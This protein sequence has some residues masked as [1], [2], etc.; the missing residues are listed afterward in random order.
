MNRTSVR[1]VGV[2]G[3][4]VTLLSL[5]AAPAFA[6]QPG[7]VQGR[8]IDAGTERPIRGAAVFLLGRDRPLVTD[9]DGRY[10]IGNV[11]AGAQTIR[12]LAL[13]YL[14]R[15]QQVTV[16]AGGSATADFGLERT[17]IP[18]D[19][20]VVTGTG[21]AVA[22][23]KLGTTLTVINAAEI[24]QAAATSVDPLLQGRTGGAAIMATSAQPGTGNM[25]S[26]RGVSSVAGSQMP[27]I[28]VDGVRV[29]NSDDTASGTGG[30]ESSALADLLVTD[31]ERIEITKGGAASTLYGS[32]AAAG[33]IQIFTKK[34]TPGPTRITARI[35]QGIDI[36][37]LKF[38]FDAGVIFPDVVADGE[39]ARFLENNFFRSG[40][41]Q[42]YYVGA[43]GGSEALT[44]SV[45]G[46]IQQA[47]GVQPK[48]ES[49]LFN[50]RGALQ[51]QLGNKSRVTFTANYTRSR[52]DRLF[53]GA[54]IA[55]PL[56]T[57]E[58]GD[59]LFFSNTDPCDAA[60]F[61][62]PGPE[63]TC[64]LHNALNIFLLPDIDETVNRF[65]FSTGLLY[66]GSDLF[67]LRGSVGLDYRA[68]HQREFEPIGFI[69]G[70]P[71]GELNR[72]NREFTS[73]S[74]DVAGTF[75][76]P[77]ATDSW[78]TSDFTV[79]VQGFRD[80]ISVVNANGNAFGLPGAPD[81]DEAA[82]VTAFE[83]NTEIFNGG[84]ILQEE[85]GLGDRV[86]LTG[87]LRI[88][89]NSTF[90]NDVNTEVYPKLSA[91]YLISDEDFFGNVFGNTVNS[92]KLRLAYGQTGKFPD[93]FLRDRSFSSIQ[94]R[95]ESAPTFANPGNPDLAPEVTAT[96]EG[97]FDV[98]L[99]S[100]RVGLHFTYYNA[101]T[102]DALF[103]V[104]EQ[105]STGQGTQLR[106]VGEVVNK[107]IEIEANFQIL[108]TR[109]VSLNFAGT[110]STVDNEVTKMG[111]ASPFSIAG[112][113]GNQ[114]IE[115]GHPIGAW[116]VNTPIDTNGDGLFDSFESQ[117][118][119]ESPIPTKLGTLAM[120]LTL[121]NNLSFSA[122]GDWATGFQAMDWGS[123]WATFNG[124][125][126]RELV[127]PGFVWPERFDLAGNPACS[128]PPCKFSQSQAR[129]ALLVDGDWFK[130]REIALR[131]RVP[132]TFARNFG[133]DRMTVYG[134]VRNLAIFSRN[135]MIDGELNGVR[136]AENLNLGGISSVTLSPPRQ[137]RFGFEVT[138]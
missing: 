52:F 56:T 27:F 73:V 107:G 58:V 71:E 114:R 24:E 25:I 14:A 16:A 126:R 103:R 81:F 86:F 4:L 100:N 5:V 8:V 96:L 47:D 136:S 80:D 130:L 119:G 65:R 68:N 9:D 79:G 135:P 66:R 128:D 77:R 17:A 111:S 138:F 43:D 120:N 49:E 6:Q 137:Y 133:I 101:K 11:P 78:W 31:I 74:V 41:A 131:Y 61:S 93:A 87:G 113:S 95:G 63:R 76:Y 110:Y 117:F 51:A 109:N 83:T 132:D 19:E 59:A 7:T 23:K 115:E 84:V 29:D 32:D 123:R 10:Q 62:T 124:I 3:C 38:M 64:G 20:I 46:R 12:V 40:H 97:G 21:R 18:L 105:P 34:G 48:N 92:L 112:T 134:T 30:E 15:Q 53:N 82:N 70:E 39:D 98:A 33:V 106:N 108:D 28:Y 118:T 94:F 72:R 55:D 42:T 69:P 2:G 85:I 35:E 13:G 99:L 89:A 127:D 102:T 1:A 54:A 60:D 26:F 36:P 22:R 67:N 121:W 75:S 116:F 125:H 44:Y 45:S 37:H 90:G 50:L 57:F 91:A 129:S 88:D 104:P 122:R